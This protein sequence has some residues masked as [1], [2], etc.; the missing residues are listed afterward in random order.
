[1]S[2]T[3]DNFTKQLHDNLEAIEDRA[4]LLKESVQSATKN[5]EVELQSKL[6]GMKTNLAAKKQ[7][8]ERYR[9]KLQTQFEETESE[10]KSNVEEWKTSREVK[11]L[12]HRADK[13]EDYANTTILFAMATMEEAEAATL[14]AICTRLDATTAAGTTHK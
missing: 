10:V 14:K 1:M 5:T 13:A 4:K 8:F 7:E 3:I 12:E 9:A 11:K 2:T 6:D